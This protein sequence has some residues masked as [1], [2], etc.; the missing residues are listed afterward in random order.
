M[1]G[2][3]GT[4]C[5][6]LSPVCF[7]FKEMPLINRFSFIAMTSVPQPSFLY[8]CFGGCEL[9]LRMLKTA[10]FQVRLCYSMG[11]LKFCGPQYRLV[12]L[13]WEYQ[14]T[15]LLRLYQSTF[16]HKQI[17]FWILCWK[18]FEVFYNYAFILLL[19]VLITGAHP[20]LRH[21]VFLSI[22]FFF[23]VFKWAR[24]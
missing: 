5:W 3:P 22:Q 21:F 16:K 11:I 14:W 13:P 8:L 4:L 15:H 1:R 9:A 12:V 6:L 10:C 17:G 19:S 24:R 2:K 18:M 23:V 7:H 20:Q